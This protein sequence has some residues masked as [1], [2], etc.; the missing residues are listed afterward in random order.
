LDFIFQSCSIITFGLL[1]QKN[2]FPSGKIINMDTNASHQ[3]APILRE[4][5]SIPTWFSI[6][7]FIVDS[8]E[9]VGYLSTDYQ[10]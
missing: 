10:V 4:I 8:L 7:D 5:R 6:V 1:V 2:G 9:E 3:S